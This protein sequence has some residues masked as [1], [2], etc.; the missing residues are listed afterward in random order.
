MVQSKRKFA[1]GTERMAQTVF[2]QNDF[3]WA[4]SAGSLP[5][6]STIQV[7][8]ASGASRMIESPSPAATRFVASVRAWPLYS[9]AA[10]RARQSP[11]MPDGMSACVMIRRRPGTAIFQWAQLKFG[12]PW[13]VN[14]GFSQFA[15]SGEALL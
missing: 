1:P 10:P 7:P 6:P 2:A 11:S 9:P 13:I 8:L 12:S 4:Y 15:Q 5:S 14:Q 3:Q